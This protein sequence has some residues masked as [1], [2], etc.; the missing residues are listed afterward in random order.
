MGVDLLSPNRYGELLAKSLP[1]VIQSDADFDQ[2]VA[3]LE[4][5]DLQERPL[6][7]E[8]QAL[9]ALLA[10]LIEDFDERRHP[11]PQL[12]PA[13]M[14]QWLLEQRGLRQRDLVPLL[15]ASSVVSDVVNGKRSISKSQAKKL[16]AFFR[17]PVE[18]FL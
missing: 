9:A 11:L 5:L 2:M 15:G 17:V 7:P 3:Q 4:A 13:E 1:R 6:T 18:V 10:R 8:E 14:L 16:A 12:P